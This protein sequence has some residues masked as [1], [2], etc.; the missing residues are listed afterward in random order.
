ML[1]SVQY[2]I[3]TYHFVAQWRIQT[4]AMDC[5][6]PMK[7]ANLNLIQY[8]NFVL[9]KNNGQGRDSIFRRGDNFVQIVR[10]HIKQ[11][12]SRPAAEVTG[13]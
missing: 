2:C 11:V 1:L 4:G 6:K 10:T 3:K 8:K 12:V 5:R 13:W 7:T 9:G